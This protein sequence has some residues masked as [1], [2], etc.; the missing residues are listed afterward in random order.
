MGS[1][2]STAVDVSESLE[3]GPEII[4][5]ENIHNDYINAEYNIKL[6]RKPIYE[7]IKRVFDIIASTIALIILSP[8][9]LITMIAIIIDDPG[10][11]FFTQERVG[12]DGRKF[13]IYKFRS[14]YK[15][16]EEKKKE[17]LALNESDG[18]LFKISSDPR[19]TKVGRFI[20]KTS[21]DELPQLIN[22]LK[23]DMS[24]IGPRPFI[25]S[26]QEQFPDFRLI[27]KPGLSCYWQIGGKNQ[28][29]AEDQLELDRKYINERSIKVDIKIIFL[30][31][32]Q[33][34][35]F[36]NL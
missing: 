13:K 36:N 25:V 11:P 20:R 5:T 14:M 21:I 15:N 30:T 31:I 12:K 26:E 23:N 29:T 6:K 17:I 8:V 18:P 9:F 35:H 28:L 1:L 7:I 3:S 27:V 16:A 10:N 2:N 19:I 4:V 24:V 33:V 22:I 34:L 32:A